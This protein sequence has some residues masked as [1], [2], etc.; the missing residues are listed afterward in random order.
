LPN[1]LEPNGAAIANKIRL[2]SSTVEKSPSG[3]PPKKAEIQTDRRS[4]ARYPS[5]EPAELETLL[6][7]REPAY[8]T[9]LDVS[10]SG[11]RI[12]IPRRVERGEQVQVKLHRSVI[13]GEVRYCRPVS[14]G[15]Q[16]GIRIQDLVRPGG[17]KNE[18]LSE[19]AIS[20][21]AVG[22]GLAVTEVIELREHLADCESCRKRV[23]EKDT[24]LNPS[25]RTRRL[26]PKEF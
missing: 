21:Y 13:F 11:L 12:A 5:Q 10:R 25:R 9:I 24:L 4:E 17:R 16:A 7:N 20:L 23:A 6:G 22:K 18:H 19:D 3:D 8:G 15:F 2:S 14:G 26:P 1:Q